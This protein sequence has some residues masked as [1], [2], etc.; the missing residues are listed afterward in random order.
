[1][2]T[3]Q[4]HK[5][6]TLQDT[7]KKWPPSNADVEGTSHV[8]NVSAGKLR[9]FK[10]SNNISDCK[11]SKWRQRVTTYLHSW[12]SAWK[13]IL[14]TCTIILYFHWFIHVSICAKYGLQS[15]RHIMYKH[16][17][18]NISC[19]SIYLLHS[20]TIPF[21]TKLQCILYHGLMNLIFS[22]NS[23]IFM[24]STKQAIVNLPKY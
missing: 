10:E 7:A 23:Y 11:W 2:T 14:W 20:T 18:P 1:M 15:I 9:L 8:T 6:S 3:A 12:F 24:F 16:N 17:S 4:I 22:L 13:C 21:I 5:I 19:W